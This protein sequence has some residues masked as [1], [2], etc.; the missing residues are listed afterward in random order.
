MLYRQVCDILI[1]FMNRNLKMMPGTRTEG[2][3]LK[4]LLLVKIASHDIS[5]LSSLCGHSMNKQDKWNR[6]VG[7]YLLIVQVLYSQ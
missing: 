2:F 4:P 6:C 5:P 1:L 3:T 7:A